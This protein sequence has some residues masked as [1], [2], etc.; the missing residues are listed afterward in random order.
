MDWLNDNV[1]LFW[2]GVALVG[3]VIIVW[4]LYQAASG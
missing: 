3:A 2:I 4:L 1:W